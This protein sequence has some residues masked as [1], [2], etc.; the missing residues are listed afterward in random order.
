[1]RFWWRGQ[2][3]RATR[4]LCWIDDSNGTSIFSSYLR[5]DKL[6]A[7][8][9]ELNSAGI[10]KSPNHINAF[11]FHLNGPVYVAKVF[12]LCNKLFWLLSY[13]RMRQRSADPGLTTCR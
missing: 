1:M 4:S 9:A 13:E 3:G 5:N 7:N 11:G 2:S 8:Q 12:D 6:N 10:Q